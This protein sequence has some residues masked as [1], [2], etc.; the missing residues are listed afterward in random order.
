MQIEWVRFDRER[1]NP[2][3]L[4]AVRQGAREGTLLDVATDQI[5]IA[6]LLRNLRESLTV[7]E[8]EQGLRLEFRPTS[9]FSDKPIR[10]PEH[11]RTIESERAHSTALVDNDYVV[12][13]Y[14]TLEAGINPEIEMGRFLADVAGFANTPALLGSVELIED[15]QRSAIGVLHA[16]V[17][18]QG[19]AWTVTAAYLDRFVDEQRLLAASET[20]RRSED[21]V[22]YLRYMSQ[23]GRRVA[24]LH[25]ALAG[26]MELAEF[27][28]EPIRAEDVQR[29]TGDILVR[30]ERV[31]DAL[32]Q[33]RDRL[34]EADRPLADQLL[35]LQS[36]LPERLK[37]L[38]PRGIDGLNIRH[39]GDF[40]LGQM[41]IVKDDIFIIDFE[42]EPR[43]TLAERRRKAPAARDVAGLIRSIDY[44]A[45]AAL[46][47]ALKMGHDDAGK[48]GAA[49]AEWRDRATA[50][51]LASYREHVGNQ[52]LWPA[53]PDAAEQM[54]DFFLIEKAFYEIEYELAHRPDWLRVPLTGILRILARQ[55]HEAA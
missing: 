17:L 41:L 46:E 43:R 23:C 18:N 29:W 19:D 16:F 38:L 50:A 13:I 40:H 44:S 36:A 55:P 4:A 8:S 45:T 22:A 37:T 52:R 10:Q 30:A 47:R 11:I 39:H 6:L 21:Q 5:F 27:A 54:L 9:R 48:L 12:K 35:A 49:L 14:R 25:I 26:N 31:F 7:D 15:D 28:P 20:A 2:H 34:K 3:A 53:D 51:F 32:K 24:E 42:G 1:Y 33:R